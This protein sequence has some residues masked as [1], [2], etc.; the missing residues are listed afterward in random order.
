M[1]LSFSERPEIVMK[2]IH[3]PVKFVRVG[4]APPEHMMIVCLYIVIGYMYP[5]MIRKA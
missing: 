5:E 3:H 4:Q 1:Y 2:I